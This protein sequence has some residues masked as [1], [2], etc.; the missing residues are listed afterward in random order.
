MTQK[1][2]RVSNTV[3]VFLLLFMFYLITNRFKN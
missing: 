1:I 3:W 2:K